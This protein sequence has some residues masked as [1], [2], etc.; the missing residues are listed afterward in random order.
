MRVRAVPVALNFPPQ[1]WM[2]T[3]DKSETAINIGFATQMLSTEM[4]LLQVFG[5]DKDHVMSRLSE[6]AK[7]LDSLSE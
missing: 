4:E 5:R 2:L 1:I 6:A 3:G 7:S